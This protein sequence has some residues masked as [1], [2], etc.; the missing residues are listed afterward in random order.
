[1]DTLV[2]QNINIDQRIN[3]VSAIW[4]STEYEAQHSNLHNTNIRIPRGQSQH[5]RAHT[6]IHT[7][8]LM[9]HTT[10]AHKHNIKT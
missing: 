1:M 10:H 9:T 2:Y 5:L 8:V 6:D 7:T 3:W 4:G